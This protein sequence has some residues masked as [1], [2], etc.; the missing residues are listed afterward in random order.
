MPEPG[1]ARY[2]GPRPWE[3]ELR[4]RWKPTALENMCFHGGNLPRSRHCSCYPPLRLEARME[5]IPTTVDKQAEVH[6]LR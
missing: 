1:P 3:G 6:H 2:Q 4:N 5:G